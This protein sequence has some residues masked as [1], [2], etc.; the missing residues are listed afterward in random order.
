[1]LEHLHVAFVSHVLQ[2][3][4]LLSD[5]KNCNPFWVKVYFRL[6]PLRNCL[7]FC[8]LSF[9]YLLENLVHSLF[10]CLWFWLFWILCLLFWSVFD[11]IRF[12][13][14]KT[15][16]DFNLE[17]IIELPIIDRFVKSL[18]LHRMFSRQPKHVSE[19][20]VKMGRAPYSTQID[21]LHDLAQQF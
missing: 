2:R 16:T 10:F 20:T 14:L 18:K 1:M 13:P 21:C 7:L 9:F 11:L 5:L 4:V 17:N 12:K 3:Y 19:M 6:L 8:F 15:S